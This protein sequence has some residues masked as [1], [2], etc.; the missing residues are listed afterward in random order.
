MHF[1]SA[2]QCEDAGEKGQG[3]SADL[4]E[5]LLLCRILVVYP[6]DEL[7][8]G[9]DQGVEAVVFH[10]GV[11][12]GFYHLT[13]GRDRVSIVGK[14][15]NVAIARQIAHQRQHRGLGGAELPGS[16]ERLRWRRLL[17]VFVTTGR[18]EK[19]GAAGSK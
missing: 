12:A 6:V 19:G 11:V 8:F 2:V 5:Y 15:Q 14:L 13:F 3:I 9:Y 10:Y 1:D 16:F 7:T 4:E 17:L 18:H